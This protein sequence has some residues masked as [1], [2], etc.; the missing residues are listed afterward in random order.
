MGR[1]MPILPARATPAAF[2][3]ATAFFLVATST[4]AGSTDTEIA[5]VPPASAINTQAP[6][7]ATPV[8]LAKCIR[9]TKVAGRETLL[10][11]CKECRRVT[12]NRRRP[13][14]AATADRTFRL[15]GKSHQTLSFRGPGR[16]RIT[17]DVP[18]ADV[19]DID[20][21]G[22]TKKNKKCGAIKDVRGRGP[23]LLNACMKCRLITLERI[24]PGS[25]N[26]KQPYTIGG[27][28]YIPLPLHGAR[29]ARITDDKACPRTT[30]ANR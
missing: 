10:N 28:A 24:Y 4:P 29:K 15:I 25:G 23:T 2:L 18:C 30:S 3:A 12:L 8:M 20:A 27:K 9:V 11:R 17:S 16:T 6:P 13:G 21:L 22:R 14:G 5:F 7:L 1:T 26:T 19:A